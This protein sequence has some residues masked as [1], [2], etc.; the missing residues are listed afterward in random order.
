MQFSLTEEQ[1]ILRDTV[2]RIARDKVA[3]R[4]AAIDADAVYPQDMF[5]LLRKN[6]LLALPLPTE[7]GGGGAGILS[8]VVAV[9]EMAKICYNTAYLMVLTYN[10]FECI[11]HAGNDKQKKQ[12]LAPLA[13]GE[14]RAAF[15]LSEPEAGSNAGALR[16]RAERI[17][18][19][20]KLTGQKSFITNSTV[21]DFFI[22]FAKTDPTKGNRGITA[23]VVDRETPGLT[24]GRPEKKIG[25]R[26]LPSTQLYFED[27]VISEDSRL[28]EEGS[29]FT[30]AMTGL[31][32]TRPTL[33]ARAVGLAQGALDNAVAYSKERQQFGQPISHF[34]GVRFMIA[35]M[36][37]Q[38][39]AARLLVYRAAAMMD[40][41]RT[42]EGSV[43]VE[44]AKYFS[45]EIAQQVALKAAQLYG[46]NGCVADYPAERYVRDSKLLTIAGG[47]SQIQQVHISNAV[48]GDSPPTTR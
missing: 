14:F 37:T 48:I 11:Y 46:A 40:S 26:G 21:A 16:T 36:A 13:A 43:A 45:A 9:E 44:M 5:D 22:V 20:Y 10:P 24:V 15:A 2:R 27:C 19:G 33:A 47:T 7:Y 6:D 3:P 8:T 32:R 38:T 41:G 4:A 31:T 1:E 25:G 39:E 12:Y 28:G 29:G 35:D 18:G 30:T 23:F 34:Q 42:K 17:P